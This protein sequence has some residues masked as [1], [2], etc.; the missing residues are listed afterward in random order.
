[1]KLNYFLEKVYSF[2]RFLR[3]LLLITID[4]LIIYISVLITFNFDLNKSN[5][6]NWLFIS[7]SSISTLTYFFSGFYLNITRYIGSQTY[8]KFAKKNLFVILYLPAN[9][10]E[11]NWCFSPSLK[12]RFL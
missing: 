9:P 3:V 11:N 1:M 6:I 4:I 8:Y 7:I 5:F 10:K 2:P 12:T